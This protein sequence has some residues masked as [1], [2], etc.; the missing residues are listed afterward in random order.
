M[1]NFNNIK[2]KAR[3]WRVKYTTP[4]SNYFKIVKKSQQTYSFNALH[5][6]S[7]END[8]HLCKML[9]ISMNVLADVISNPIYQSF[10][11]P[12]K[13]G[14]NRKIQA[15]DETLKDVQR[16]LNYFLNA[17]YLWIKPTVVFGFV[18][19]PSGFGKICSIAENAK[20]HVDKKQVL[21][22]DVKDFFPSITAIQVKNLFQSNLFQF[23]EHLATILALL[24]TYEG[25]LPTGAP[26]SPAIANF[27]CYA[28]DNELQKFS[29]LNDLS[30]TRYAD[31]L[32]FSANT[33]IYTDT[34]LD[35]VSIINKNHFSINEKKFRVQSSNRKQTVTGLVVNK[36]VNVDRKLIRKIRATL[37]DL[38]L[39]G[40][41]LA[42]QH[43]FKLKQTPDE[44]T[45]G[46]FVHR[47]EGLINFVGQ[48]RGKGDQIYYRFKNEFDEIFTSPINV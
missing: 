17:Y 19:Q 26:T 41:V 39:N 48:V 12:K 27:I 42:A 10:E 45:V 33:N 15:P 40:V 38:R 4:E 28:L 8:S 24:T 16:K 6:L 31:D 36:K 1:K 7:L 23:D 43:H 34:I 22:I 44:K 21:N 3:L 25:K 47:L 13:K 2:N 46:Y 14:A 29:E 18:I 20:P 9:G 35:I 37:H 11:I 32:T 30:F 5:L